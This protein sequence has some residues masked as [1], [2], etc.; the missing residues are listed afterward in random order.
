MSDDTPQEKAE[1]QAIRRR[2]VTVG[3]LVAV[4]GVLIA[5]LSLW[6]NWSD[7]KADE[8]ERRVAESKTATANARLDLRVAVI[9]DGRQVSVT[10]PAHE[11]LDTTVAFPTP[12]GVSARTPVVPAISVAWFT[13][14]LR[15]ATDGGR[16]EVEGRLP[17][18]VT[19]RYR[20]GDAVRQDRAIVDVAW[21]TSGR[22]FAG[23]GVRII[24]A[25]VRQRGGDQARIN[26]LWTAEL[27]RLKKEI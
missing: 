6:M 13:A 22:M 12:L 7:R 25:S 2:W 11:L 14:A 16:D 15:G 26:A 8:S 24:A 3:E 19:V 9:E 27:A 21:R 10:D 17:V 5:A 1:A 20:S 23:R 18:L 4:A